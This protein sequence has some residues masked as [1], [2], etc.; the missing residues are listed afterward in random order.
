MCLLL[1][2]N[3]LF[4]PYLQAETLPYRLVD[5]DQYDIFEE[6]NRAKAE[7][8]LQIEDAPDDAQLLKYTNDFWRQAV[9]AVEGDYSLDK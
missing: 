6:E 4:G 7:K 3:L 8:E 9:T 1:I 5:T 2:M